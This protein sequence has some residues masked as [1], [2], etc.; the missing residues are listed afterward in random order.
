VTEIAGILRRVKPDLVH[1]HSSK[2][3]ALGRLAARV[4]GVPVVFTA[5]GWAFADGSSW[6]RKLVAV[7]SE[8]VAG[9]LGDRIIAVSEADRQLA[10][11]FHI[12]GGRITL[13][14]NG[15]EDVPERA[16]PESGDEVRLVMVAR[17]TA[18]KDHATLIQA[19]QGVRGSWR[20]LLVGDGP[21]RGG[22]EAMAARLGIGDR[23]D[24]LGNRL[25][26][27]RLLA[28]AHVFV[29]ASRWEGLPISILEGMRA[30]LPIVASDVGGVAE[31]IEQGANGF[32]MPSE[33]V[34]AL[35][36]PLQR[37]VADRALRGRQGA[38]SRARYESEFTA[39]RMY[40]ETR[41]V[42]ESVL[43]QATGRS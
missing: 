9:E 34:E 40:Q 20:L 13:V 29:L 5:H 12:G 19:M 36:V 1:L 30:G 22:M 35:R 17:F 18:Q 23:V 15:I 8:L 3:G 38:R 27:P 26:V 10:L 41:R 31:T 2:A 4:A 33:D 32:F 21:L 39:R 7:P 11:R 42:Y 24:F 43:G 6:P 14:R 25:D 37:L 28:D 16:A